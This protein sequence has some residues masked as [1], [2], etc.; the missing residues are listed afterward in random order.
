[1]IKKEK[2]WIRVAVNRRAWKDKDLRRWR[3]FIDPDTTP[4]YVKKVVMRGFATENNSLT[5]DFD[6]ADERDVIAYLNYF[7]NIRIEDDVAYVDY[8]E[9]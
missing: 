9:P 5:K 6:K 2:V 7:G 4:I 1:M 3:I 8:L